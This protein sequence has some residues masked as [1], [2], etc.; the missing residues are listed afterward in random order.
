[1]TFWIR[2]NKNGVPIFIARKGN[3][4]HLTRDK[5]KALDISEIPEETKERFEKQFN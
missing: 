2:H 5:N 4:F 1:M 3:F